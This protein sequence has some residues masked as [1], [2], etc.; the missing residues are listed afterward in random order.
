MKQG[1]IAT[2]IKKGKYWSKIKSGEVTGYVN[3]D[4]M[5]FGT[6]VKEYADENLKKTA[7]VTA[8]TLRVREHADEDSEITTL[9]DK[10]DSLTVKH[11]EKEGW[12]KVKTSEGSG[13]V[14]EDYVD[15]DYYYGTA[16]SMKAIEA[17]RAARKAARAA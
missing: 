1:N 7:T 17:A 12:V 5:V 2:V 6:D 14:S 15:L 4:Y 9:V 11:T 3:N 8:E 13:Y 16:K 10:D